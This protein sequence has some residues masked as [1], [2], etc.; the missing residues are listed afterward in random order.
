MRESAHA[1][2]TPTDFR[3]LLR[4]LQAH[5]LELQ[6]QNEQLRVA[7]LELEASRERYRDLYDLAPIACLSL[8]ARA[9]IMQA[10]KAA[11]MLLGARPQA[12][13][14]T[15]FSRLIAGGHAA[16]FERHRRAVLS[17]EERC[18]CTLDLVLPDGERREVRMESRQT[19]DHSQREWRVAI[20]DVTEV[21][22]LQ[23]Q[24]QHAQKLEAMGTMASGVAHDFGNL[25]MAIVGGADLALS[26][27]PPDSAACEPLEELR[28][29]ALRGRSSVAQLLMFARRNET[30]GELVDVD[31]VVRGSEPL[32]RQL[33]G[34]GLTV[35]LALAAGGAQVP[36]DGAQFEQ[37]LL[38][39][40]TNA[41]H[42]MPHGGCLRIETQ[43]LDRDALDASVCSELGAQDCVRLVVSDSGVGMAEHVRA[44]AFE[45]FFTTKPSGVGTGLGLSMVYGAVKA[46]GGHCELRSQLGRG[47]S[48]EMYWPLAAPDSKREGSGVMRRP[49]RGDPAIGVL[50]VEDDRLVRLAVRHYLQRAG[51]AVLE[52]ANGVEALAV[53]ASRSAAVQILVSDVVL[54]GAPG[55][56]VVAAAKKLRP[57]LRA[58]LMSAH[59]AELLAQRG[60]FEPGARLL[61]KPFTEEELREAVR[62]ELDAESELEAIA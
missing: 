9:C 33:L 41:M 36:L 57:D 14:G 6:L 29:V 48:V 4:E 13:L 12:L 52:A 42:A 37:L 43:E 7:Q 16:V 45:P 58:M 1:L 55:P 22:R 51:Y 2:S 56:E 21:H 24:L 25:L 28:R 18:S 50:V 35:E 59:S 60:W 3:A 17:S 39:L 27:V 20:V 10:N 34:E 54:P 19:G 15:R 47:T 61:R 30:H 46:S 62:L 5:Q 40:A 49:G 32:L 23:R 31:A 38:N 8:D 53:L 44:R 26:C 11:G